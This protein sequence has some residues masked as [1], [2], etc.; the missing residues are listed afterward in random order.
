MPTFLK[1]RDVHISFHVDLPAAKK[2]RTLAGSIV[3]TAMSAALIGTAVGLTVYRLYVYSPMM[4]LTMVKLTFGTDGEIGA[5]NPRLC[6]RLPIS[7]G[8]GSLLSQQRR[9][10]SPLRPPSLL[11]LQ[12]ASPNRLLPS[13]GTRSQVGTANPARGCTPCLSLLHEARLHPRCSFKCGLRS[14]SSIRERIPPSLRIR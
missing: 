9:L 8:T 5:R 3:S 12:N 14:S 13:V 2:R 4:A 1:I 6:L 11:L 10:R 7:K